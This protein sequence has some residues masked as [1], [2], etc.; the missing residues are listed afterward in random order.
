M[1]DEADEVV[2][3]DLPPDELLQRLREGKV[4]LPQQAERAISNFFRKGNLIALR[5]LALRRTADRVDDQMRHYRRDQF[6]ETYGKPASPCSSASARARAPRRSCAPARVWPPSSMRLGMPSMSKPRP[7]AAAEESRQ[8]ILRAL[9]LAQDLGAETRRC[10]VTM[11]W[12]DGLCA[13]AQFRAVLVGRT[14]GPMATLARSLADR[15]RQPQPDLDVMQVALRNR[16]EPG[17]CQ[18]RR[19][20][21]VVSGRPM[22]AADVCAGRICCSRRRCRVCS[23]SP[24]SSCCSCSRWSWSR[25]FGRGPAVW[26][27]SRVALFDFFFVPP[28]FSF[29]VSDVQYLVTFAVM[30][31]VALISGQLTAGCISRPRWRPSRTR[32][33]ALYEMARDL[34]AALL[35]EQIAETSDASSVRQCGPS[36]NADGRRQGSAA[37][38][39][40]QAPPIQT[41]TGHGPLGLRPRRAGRS[42]HGYLAGQPAT[43]S[44]AE[45]ADAYARGPALWAPDRARAGPGTTAATETFARLVATALERVHYVEVAQATR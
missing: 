16:R 8:R 26:P 34:S 37:G 42:V 24:I 14:S 22:L 18:E 9:D 40:P 32:V 41:S 11:R 1:F 6:V 12:A 39:E 33:S 35:P 17:E 23:N 25:G 21:H 45:G 15:D 38:T 20:Q 7:G 10:R 30:L 4:Y 27:P 13:R 43:L 3:V 5:E 28:R 19:R 44:A 31:A 36:R 2:L 29:A